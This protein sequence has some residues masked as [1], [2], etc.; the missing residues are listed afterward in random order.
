VFIAAKYIVGSGY[1]KSEGKN[2]TAGGPSATGTGA[3][4]GAA[5]S[6][7][8]AAP[9]L[10]V[11]H[12]TDNHA[13]YTYPTGSDGNH[14]SIPAPA[15]PHTS[16]P[17]AH[18]Y[19]EAHE[20]RWVHGN[21]IHHSD[22]GGHYNHNHMCSG[23]H[24]S[25]YAHGFGPYHDGRPLIPASHYYYVNSIDHSGSVG[26][27]TYYGP[28]YSDT[29][30]VF[31]HCSWYGG[32][33]K[34]HTWYVHG[35]WPRQHHDNHRV[36]YAYRTGPVK[37]AGHIT[38]TGGAAGPGGTAGTNGTNGSTTAGT[39]GKSGGGGGVICISDEVIP[40]TITTSTAGGS[41]GGSSAS[42]GML[43]TVINK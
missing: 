21:Y 28:N 25:N 35:K 8:S 43:V 24:E 40:E 9:N 2:A 29:G 33:S 37:T 26:S 30:V 15:L 42:S 17:D 6:N 3:T 7:G 23:G 18:T 22:H 4:N 10:S 41:L 32:H 27:G 13:H 39:D 1:I 31:P 12:Y 14:A 34:G 38:A 20:H 36:Y 16:F 11:A 5:G 19:K